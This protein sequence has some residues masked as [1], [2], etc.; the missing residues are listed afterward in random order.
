MRK[1]IGVKEK[2][3]SGTKDT[4]LSSKAAFI[5]RLFP[6]TSGFS[7]KGVGMVHVKEATVRN[8]I[9]LYGADKGEKCVSPEI[10]SLK[11]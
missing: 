4:G 9:P 1:A 3:S 2:E 11:G 10:F 6:L 8:S 7:E 5:F